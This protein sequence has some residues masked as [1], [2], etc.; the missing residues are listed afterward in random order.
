MK[1][2]SLDLRERVAAAVEHHEGSQREIARRFRV[3]LSFITRLRRRHRW[4]G[5]LHPQP[6]GG[7]HPP[8][9]DEAACDRL[10]EALRQQPDATL[11]ELRRRL[12]LSCS[13]TALWRTLRR[14]KITRKKKTRRHEEQSR[15][16]V[17]AQRASCVEEVAALDP[18]GLIFVDESG[19]TTAMTRAYGRAPAGERVPG[20]VPGHWE[21]V[22]MLSGMRLSGVVAPWAFEGATD[23]AAFETY[24]T[25]VLAPQLRPGDVVVWDNLQAHKS[26]A[27]VRA[28][29][30]AGATVKPLPPHSPDLTPIEKLWSKVK[31]RLRSLAARTVRRVYRALGIALQ[32][33][34]SQDIHG[35]FQS[36]GLCPTQT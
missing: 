10:R 4:S 17:Q 18:E 2:Y 16:D 33:V 34:T 23:S 24:V 35:W 5:D 13:L 9:L 28:V 12:R 3:S 22:T 14:L 1:P 27:A 15:P 25:E 19:A 31:G 26:A 7:G 21:S 6:H 11:A 8:A 29:E 30:A 32:E 36:C 20:A